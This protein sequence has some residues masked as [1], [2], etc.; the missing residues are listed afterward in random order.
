MGGRENESRRVEGNKS[1]SCPWIVTRVTAPAP[2]ILSWNDSWTDSWLVVAI[3]LASLIVQ[4][5][6]SIVPSCLFSSRSP[7]SQPPFSPS[8]SPQRAPAAMS[9]SQHPWAGQPPHKQPQHTAPP[10]PRPPILT[11]AAL[12]THLTTLETLFLPKLTLGTSHITTPVLFL[13]GTA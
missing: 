13:V 1:R 3:S 12:A 6:S 4:H 5:A 8:T 2:M 7:S 9:L 11:S 10:Q